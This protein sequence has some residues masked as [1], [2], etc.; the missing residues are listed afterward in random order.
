MFAGRR[1]DGSEAGAIAWQ[2]EV[3]GQL[4][5]EDEVHPSRQPQEGGLPQWTP[6]KGQ[7]QQEWTWPA[8]KPR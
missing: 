5:A 7:A 8:S 4:Q 6:L 3:H 1:E 2:Q